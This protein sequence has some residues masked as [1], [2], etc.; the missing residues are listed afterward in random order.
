MDRLAPAGPRYSTPSTARTDAR[1]AER[2]SPPLLGVSGH[3]HRC[4]CRLLPLED[5]WRW[6]WE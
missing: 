3:A 6:R 1:R 2:R 5:A 4:G